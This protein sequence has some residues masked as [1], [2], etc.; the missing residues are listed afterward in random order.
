MME[1]GTGKESLWSKNSIQILV[2][3]NFQYNWRLSWNLW[4]VAFIRVMHKFSKIVIEKTQYTTNMTVANFSS[5][6]V[7]YWWSL[8][9]ILINIILNIKLAKLCR[10]VPQV[11]SFSSKKGLPSPS[12]SK[13]SDEP[14]RMKTKPKLKAI[15]RTTYVKITMKMSFITLVMLTTIGPNLLSNNSQQTNLN[16]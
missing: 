9:R 14:S 3:W 11:P 16:K 13:S 10:N 7:R 4:I 6:S 5:C 15:M 12:S 8:F 2:F 1:N